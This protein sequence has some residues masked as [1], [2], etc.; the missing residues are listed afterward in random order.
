MSGRGFEQLLLRILSINFIA[1]RYYF[2]PW[3]VDLNI[4]LVIN[5]ALTSNVIDKTNFKRC[6]QVIVS[7]H[8]RHRL[9]SIYSELILVEAQFDLVAFFLKTQALR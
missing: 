6:F 1:R 5:Y 8:T 7:N 2:K 9:V 4:E 3:H